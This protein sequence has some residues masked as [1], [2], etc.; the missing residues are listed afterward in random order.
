MAKEKGQYVQATKDDVAHFEEWETTRRMYSQLCLL[1]TM[2]YL[3]M[4]RLQKRFEM[5][6]LHM[7]HEQKQMITRTIA[8]LSEAAKLLGLQDYMASGLGKGGEKDFIKMNTTLAREGYEGIRLLLNWQNATRHGAN[9]PKEI[10][11]Y[12][13]GLS[14]GKKR[15][16]TKKL[17]DTFHLQEDK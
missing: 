5:H 12:L 15:Y 17:I 4:L 14:T 10:E 13:N 16:F 3:L 8:Y 1:G 9:N 11:K 6:R 7:T 2:Q